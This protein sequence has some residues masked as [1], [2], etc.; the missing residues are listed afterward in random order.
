VELALE[1]ALELGLEPA[2]DCCKD[3][4]LY[5]SG[6]ISRD[7]AR[8]LRRQERILS[9]THCP[10]D[11]M[12]CTL[13]LQLGLGLELAQELELGLAQELEPVE[14]YCKDTNLSTL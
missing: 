3:T 4:C 2:E 14:A 1:L 13:C 10:A 11:S 5:T 9:S 8:R 7:T 12:H 6:R